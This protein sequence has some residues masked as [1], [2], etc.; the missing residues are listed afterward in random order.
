MGVI[1]LRTF[2][3][4]G[5]VVLFFRMMGKREIGEISLFDI[6][7][8]MMMA[9]IAALSLENAD[10][11]MFHSVLPMFL[12]VMIQR[13]MAFF[14]LKSKKFRDAF[15]GKSSLIIYN[16]RIDDV[17]MKKQRYNYDDLM[18]QLHEKGVKAIQDVEYA[19]LEPSGKLSVF[20]KESP[21]SIG[22]V[23][24]LITD[25]DLQNDELKRLQKTVDWLRDELSQLGYDDLNSITYCTY[26]QGGQWFVH[27]K[28]T[29]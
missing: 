3:I 12:L 25:G 13:L 22:Y 18:Q 21:I 19:I 14:S 24:L 28:Q 2:I 5:F 1:V 17:E 27:L 9:E 16:D 7:I 8:F 15:E 10:K 20:A 11:P 23:Y 26:D 4:Y 29:N 6:V